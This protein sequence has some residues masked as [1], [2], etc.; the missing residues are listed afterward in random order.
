MPESPAPVSRRCTVNTSTAKEQCLPTKKPK[1]PILISQTTPKK[2]KKIEFSDEDEV[3]QFQAD[4][5]L[6]T[7]YQASKYS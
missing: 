6:E 1:Q 5:T 2:D 3:G 4:D 7:W